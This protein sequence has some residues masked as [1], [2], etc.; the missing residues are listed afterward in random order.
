MVKSKKKMAMARVEVCEANGAFMH[1]WW[2][3]KMIQ[4]L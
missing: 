3:P 4:P 1:W 2:L